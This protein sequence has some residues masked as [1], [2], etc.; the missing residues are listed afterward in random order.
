MAYSPS[1]L[2]A[3]LGSWMNTRTQAWD[4]SISEDLN[5]VPLKATYDRIEAI[6]DRITDLQKRK[7]DLRR[8][9]AEGKTGIIRDYLKI[10][11]RKTSTM[12]RAKDSRNDKLDK[13][14]QIEANNR[15]RE[16]D[17]VA[18]NGT[19]AFGEV[20]AGQRRVG[21]DRLENA[22]TNVPTWEHGDWKA[23]WMAAVGEHADQSAIYGRDGAPKLSPGKVHPGEG[24]TPG[25]IIGY[26]DMI[27]AK[28]G[29]GMADAFF[30]GV[31]RQ[32]GAIKS[33]FRDIQHF[34]K[35]YKWDYLP[36]DAELEARD[37]IETS[38]PAEFVAKT[39]EY[40]Q[41]EAALALAFWREINADG[42]QAQVGID[43]L[44]AAIAEAKGDIDEFELKLEGLKVDS[45]SMF[46]SPLGLLMNPYIRYVDKNGRALSDAA[47][48][49][50]KAIGK[51][52][53]S[54]LRALGKKLTEYKDLEEGVEDIGGKMLADGTDEVANDIV[55]KTPPEPEEVPEGEAAE[56]AAGEAPEEGVVPEEEAA[57]VAAEEEVV[58]EEAPVEEDESNW[59]LDNVG[60]LGEV[61]R[62][63]ADIA[64]AK[65]QLEADMDAAQAAGDNEAATRLA[66]ALRNV[67]KFESSLMAIRGGLVEN[68][69]QSP[70]GVVLGLGAGASSFIDSAKAATTAIAENTTDPVEQ[71]RVLSELAAIPQ[72]RRTAPGQEPGRR[73]LPKAPSKLQ[74]EFSPPSMEPTDLL[75]RATAPEPI[76]AR[77]AKWVES[78]EEA[79]SDDKL[80]LDEI[81]LFLELDEINQSMPE[82]HVWGAIMDNPKQ[83]P[84][85]L[86][87]FDAA[88]DQGMHDEETHNKIREVLAQQTV[89]NMDPDTLPVPWGEPESEMKQRSFLKED[90][91]SADLAMANAAEVTK[92]DL[93]LSVGY[94][95][96]PEHVR[97]TGALQD[98][99]ERQ[100]ALDFASPME[101]QNSF[102]KLLSGGPGGLSDDMRGGAHKALV[103][104]LD[105]ASPEA[106]EY[107]ER[108]PSGQ[109]VYQEMMQ[110]LAE[111][112]GPA[113]PR[114]VASANLRRISDK[115]EGV[116]ISAVPG[117]GDASV[118]QL[119]KS[120]RLARENE[121][122]TRR[123]EQE[124]R[125][126]SDFGP[127][128]SIRWQ[129]YADE[130]EKQLE[131][132]G[133]MPLESPSY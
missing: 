68:P 75:A 36:V 110:Y 15:M 65:S 126:R 4:A 94:Q 105:R 37:A 43:E 78:A 113:M 111:N 16:H 62:K 10:E 86:R 39:S 38:T 69:D 25:V 70:E 42:D 124:L 20:T 7:G 115:R 107:F 112:P 122:R 88:Y 100:A 79:L 91:P 30:D 99:R 26:Y 102:W 131:L 32:P 123:E 87:L 13:L 73:V 48:E 74:M 34:K 5:S 2:E 109:R 28:F 130:I 41:P 1:V 22:K 104:N 61:D 31:T 76:E 108:D 93:P 81:D 132:R 67:E 52:T 44:D 121:D 12:M 95:G 53:P 103:S 128:E 96:I 119:Q 90:D 63:L 85:M 24:K 101:I 27:E 72:G 125:G 29:K 80:Q 50:N 3:W 51:L 60:T 84:M 23:W 57:E 64:T 98:E 14:V 106:L 56:V 114:R 77:I 17:Q 117:F 11:G 82:G 19:F 35:V 89:M 8:A 97:E 49:M 83:R 58:V 21:M 133:A 116:G 9:Q 66:D 120:L 127:T 59:L 129:G 18:Q 45:K 47:L 33:P 6:T 55:A 46:G 92:K 54:Q 40:K 118:E 71:D